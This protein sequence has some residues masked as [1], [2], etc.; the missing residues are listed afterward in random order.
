MISIILY[1]MKA[2]CNILYY[3]RPVCIVFYYIKLYNTYL[4]IDHVTD[5]SQQVL[6]RKH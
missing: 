6:N 1:N 3:I 4:L 5:R 2:Y